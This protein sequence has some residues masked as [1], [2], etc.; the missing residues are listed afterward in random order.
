M[1]SSPAVTVPPRQSTGQLS[2]WSLVI[3]F[4][5]MFVFFVLPMCDGGSRSSKT[6]GVFERATQKNGQRTSRRNDRCRAPANRRHRQLVQHLQQ[7]ST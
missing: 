7:A 5:L 3:S 2:G 1:Y 4:G 6:D